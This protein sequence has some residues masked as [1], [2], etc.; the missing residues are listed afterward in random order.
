MT[1]TYVTE[2][3]KKKKKKERKAHTAKYLSGY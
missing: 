3:K 1:A 2:G